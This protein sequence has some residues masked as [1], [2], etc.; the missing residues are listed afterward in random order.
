[1]WTLVLA[2]AVATPGA[3]EPALGADDENADSDDAPA[4]TTLQFPGAILGTALWAGLRA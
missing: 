2:V 4:A 3:S 1:V